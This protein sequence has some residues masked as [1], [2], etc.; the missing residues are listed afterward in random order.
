M[1]YKLA[2]LIIYILTSLI[3]RLEICGAENI[4]STGTYIVAGNH[5]GRLDVPLIYYLL[6][7]PDVIL[8]VA[9]KYRQ[10][11]LWRWFVKQLDGIYIDRFNADFSAL[12]TTLQR[13]RQGGVLVLSPEG[14]RSPT[15]ALIEARGG[16]GYLAAKAGVPIIPAALTGTEDHLV[17]ARLRRL[18]RVPVKLKVGKPFLLPP[19]P[20]RDRE[21][22]LEQYTE[23]IMCQIAALL[24]PA[25][26]GVY[27][28]HPRL[29]ELLA[30]DG[31]RTNQS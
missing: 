8:L 29:K 25:Y 11:A 2:R 15:G 14:T 1:G 26:R 3:V 18:Q 12:R 5:L 30:N 10:S 28:E 23:E 16:T 6:D 24:P 22:A 13:L 4:P 9:E 19:L 31:G 27:A 20:A 17:K 7:R 21:A